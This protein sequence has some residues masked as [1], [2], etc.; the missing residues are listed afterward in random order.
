MA[1][2][3]GFESKLKWQD[4]FG[5]C[6]NYSAVKVVFLTCLSHSKRLIFTSLGPRLTMGIKLFSPKTFPWALNEMYK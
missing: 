2:I 4:P 5:N 6:G 3:T 1:A